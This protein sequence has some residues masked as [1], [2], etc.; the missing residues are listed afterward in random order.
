MDGMGVLNG[1]VYDGINLDG[2]K[3][4]RQEVGAANPTI[5]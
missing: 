5:I 1:W 2:G 3:L 4:I